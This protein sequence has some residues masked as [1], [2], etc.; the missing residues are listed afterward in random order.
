MAAAAAAAITAAKIFG[1]FLLPA[2][3]TALLRLAFKSSELVF[4]VF[5]EF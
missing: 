3:A 2:A 5:V 1:S 4:V